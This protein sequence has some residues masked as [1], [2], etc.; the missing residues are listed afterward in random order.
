[1]TIGI[2]QGWALA[3]LNQL[4]TL[5]INTVWD[6]VIVQAV[7]SCE[8]AILSANLAG[9]SL[10]IC[11]WDLRRFAKWSFSAVEEVV[12]KMSLT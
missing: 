10:E 8:K 5:S 12:A 1:V 3:W 7:W 6:K 4:M 11:H 9:L 2:S